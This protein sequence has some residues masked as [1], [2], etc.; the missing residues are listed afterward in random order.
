MDIA[1][2]ILVGVGGLLL[3][4]AGLHG[5]ANQSVT[6]IAFGAGAVLI[7]VGGC[8]Y[9]QDALWKR[10]AEAR[11]GQE[12]LVFN[13]AFE[14]VLSSQDVRAAS[15]WLRYRYGDH[16]CASPISD[17]VYLRIT[18]GPSSHPLF[19][20]HYSLQV[21]ATGK[22]WQRA[23]T[24]DRDAIKR[25]TVF[26]I[27]ETHGLAGA[28]PA[29]FEEPQF[30]SVIKERNIGAGESVR[31]LLLIERP[32]ALQGPAE[33]RQ[34]RITLK[35]VNGAQGVVDVAPPQP[36]KESLTSV[37]FGVGERENLSD[38]KFLLYDERTK[39]P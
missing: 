6:I 2:Y 24:F 35:D 28:R 8:C 13:A 32:D 1:A 18:N 15:F 25:G 27:D 31:G 16:L 11:R 26:G 22:E 37:R 38:C 29:T 7:V 14:T 39:L 4:F 19:I 17:V 36:R 5:F 12:G 23:N 33:S 3:A 21:R 10:E 34:W 20:D 30:E 9:W